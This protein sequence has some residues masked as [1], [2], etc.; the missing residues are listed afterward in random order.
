MLKLIRLEWKKHTV[1]KYIR[2]AAITTASIVAILL[3]MSSDATTGEL[4]LGTGKSVIHAVTELYFNMA[5]LVFTGAMLASFIVS[6]Y[7]NKLINLM[8]SYPIK[9]KKVLL[10]KVLSVCIFNFLALVLSK[11]IAY[12][13][14]LLANFEAAESID[15]L[16][17]TALGSS[18]LSGIFSVCGGCIVLL[19]G[20]KMKSA[21]ATL[22]AAFV[23]MLVVMGIT[24]G[25]VL[26]YTSI[27]GIIGYVI[28]IAGAW[29]AV[30]WAIRGAETEDVM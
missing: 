26:P 4:A 23:L 20:M 24:Q 8:F 21:R 22:I 11:A 28:Q 7:E 14:L 9:R 30:F 5:F 6:E 2:N 25:N 17:F 16:S 1:W 12:A 3:L 15:I 10:A 13:A 29:I 27:N 18:L 19:I